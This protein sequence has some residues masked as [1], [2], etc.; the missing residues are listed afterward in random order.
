MT[1]GKNEKLRV[2]DKFQTTRSHGIIPAGAVV[3]V[4]RVE[5]THPSGWYWIK[6]RHGHRTAYMAVECGSED[7]LRNSVLG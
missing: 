2:G 4:V 5:K 7:K 6:I 1:M 3:E